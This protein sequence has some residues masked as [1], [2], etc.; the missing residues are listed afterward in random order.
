MNERCGMFFGGMSNAR[1]HAER[2]LADLG[3]D[4]DYCSAFGL[5]FDRLRSMTM[6][7]QRGLTGRGA[8]PR[9][10]KA[11]GEAT[12]R[13]IEEHRTTGR[14]LLLPRDHVAVQEFRWKP[15]G[16]L[17]L[18]FYTRY[19]G[20]AFEGWYSTDALKRA[21]EDGVLS[22]DDNGNPVIDPGKAKAPTMDRGPAWIG[23]GI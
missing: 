23:E 10:S 11:K 2:W 22:W 6:D 21:E 17:D 19:K 1:A 16:G 4:P 5:D 8:M 13:A 15:G 12:R 14:P 20:R 7:I 9:R 3:I 18:E